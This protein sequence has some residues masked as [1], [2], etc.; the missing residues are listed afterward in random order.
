MATK[1]KAAK[2]APAKKASK[3]YKVSPLRGMSIEAWI[4]AKTSGWQSD[5]I[6]RMVAV[7]KKAA[8][9]S[10]AAIKWSQPIFE[11]NGPFAFIKPA[12]AHVSFGFWR[13]AEV[14]DPKGIL[15]RGD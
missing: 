12:K 1:R 7:V 9:E 2:K 11:Q 6:R 14:V 4:K 10:V 13:G 8:P 15:E 3:I 5:V